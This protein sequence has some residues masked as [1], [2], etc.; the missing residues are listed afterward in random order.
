MNKFLP[1]KAIVVLVI[2]ALGALSACGGD[3]STDKKD[4][5]GFK[6]VEAPLTKPPTEIRALGPL[7]KAPEPGKTVAFI[8]SGIPMFSYYQDQFKE[9]I[10]S[11]GWKMKV[12]TYTD[13]PASALT[14][15]ISSGV[16]YIYGQSLPEEQVKTQLAAAHKAGI[17]VVNQGTAVQSD[18]EN[19]YYTFLTDVSSDGD[20]AANWI[21][22]DSKGTANVAHLTMNAAAL[23]AALTEPLKKTYGACATCELATVDVTPAEI[24]S[25]AIPKILSTYLQSHPDVN[26]IHAQFADLMTNVVPTLKTSGLAGKVKIL[27]A[28]ADQNAFKQIASGE[29]AAGTAFPNGAMA[30]GAA[31]MFA[32]LDVEPDSLTAEVLKS[33]AVQRG[34]ADPWIV[35]DKKVA[36]ELSKLQFG[37]PGPDGFQDQYKAQWKVG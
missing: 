13:D 3:S 2:A 27:V 20:A 29:I 26:Y 11:F 12:F 8:S 17:P 35:T 28:N 10:G 15:A 5:S 19:G 14:Q 18:P 4:T 36:T 25:G 24:G 23:L 21:I 31:D 33:D 1:K 9:A 22:N 16:D 32:R 7:P 34:V 6:P 37:W 30:W